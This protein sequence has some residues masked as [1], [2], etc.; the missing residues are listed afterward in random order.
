MKSYKN[1]SGEYYEEAHGKNAPKAQAFMYTSREKYFHEFMQL[2]G[3]ERILDVGCGSG[4]FTREIARKLP[5]ARIVGADISKAVIGFASETTKKEG[6]K[7]LTFVVS[8]IESIKA[9]G[10]FDVIIVSHLIEHLKNPLQALREVKKK[11]NKNGAL[12]ITT[13]NYISLWPLAEIVF[14][15]AMAKKG[16]SL[17]E[18]HI[19]RFDYWSI[20]RIIQKAGFEIQEEKTLYVFSLQASIFSTKLGNAFFAADKALDKLPFGMIIYLKATKK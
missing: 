2:K 19:S 15:K 13:P 9:K 20:R 5:K 17:E 1:I 4:T 8:G 12:F 10:K 11:L 6:L 16:Y 18:Q 14:D 7:N 3:N